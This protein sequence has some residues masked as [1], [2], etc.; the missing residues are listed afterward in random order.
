MQKSAM[1]RDWKEVYKAALFEDDSTKIPQRIAE[2]EGMHWRHE[3][4]SYS[5][6]VMI[7]FVNSR[8]WKMPDTSYACLE[9]R[10]G[11]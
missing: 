8:L 3:R 5:A 7:R 1:Y 2:A 10:K 4:L 11:Y 9:R 6:P